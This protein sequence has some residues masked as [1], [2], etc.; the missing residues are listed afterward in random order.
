[1]QHRGAGEAEKIMLPPHGYNLAEG[2]TFRARAFREI[3]WYIPCDCV[4]LCLGSGYE[5][6]VREA[7]SVFRSYWEWSYLR[8]EQEQAFAA[9]SALCR[10][11]VS[12]SIRE[13]AMAILSEITAPQE[14]GGEG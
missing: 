9:L 4:A 7:L 12:S 8:S 5:W 11:G 6:L 14:Q 10:R 3:N 13:E 2:E 1:M